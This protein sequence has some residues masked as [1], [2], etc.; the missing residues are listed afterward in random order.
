MPFM[1]KRAVIVP[2]RAATHGVLSNKNTIA[3]MLSF[4]GLGAYL[5]PPVDNLCANKVNEL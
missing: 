2:R 4:Q 1:T 5:D 3:C